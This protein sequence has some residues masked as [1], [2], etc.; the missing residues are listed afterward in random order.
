MA[1]P[2]GVA[3]AAAAGYALAAGTLDFRFGAL[4]LALFLA[5]AGTKIRSDIIDVKDDQKIAKRTVPV[6]IGDRLAL[7]TGYGVALAGIVLAAALPLVFAVTSW[8]A[9]PAMLVGATML[10]TARLD[11][12]QGSMAMAGSLFVLIVAEL[13]VLAVA[14]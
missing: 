8:F 11:P 3:C 7:R 13:A 12:F 9:V 10:L 1:Y 14:A 4:G 5:L 2:A 6:V